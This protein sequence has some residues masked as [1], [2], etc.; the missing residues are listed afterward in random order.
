M[1]SSIRLKKDRA[2][3]HPPPLITQHDTVTGSSHVATQPPLSF[4]SST[5]EYINI[6]P[7]C[8]SSHYWYPVPSAL[9][10]AA[11]P[12]TSNQYRLSFSSSEPEYIFIQPIC[13]STWYPV[14]CH[15]LQYPV[16]VCGAQC[17]QNPVTSVLPSPSVHPLLSN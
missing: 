3:L 11:V 17:N 10:Y 15:M 13:C 7:K 16:P 8:C 1:I 6:Q 5:L 9:S 12:R 14:H 4:P 2:P